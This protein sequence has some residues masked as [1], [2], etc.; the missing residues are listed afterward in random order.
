MQDEPH[1][2]RPEELEPNIRESTT[3]ATLAKSQVMSIRLSDAELRVV[4]GAA[5]RANMSVGSFL[6]RAALEAAE[7]RRLE[8]AVSVE[9]GL[10]GDSLAYQGLNTSRPSAAASAGVSL[11]SPALG[12][13]SEVA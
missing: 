11:Q 6:K 5:R 10:S 7:F 3:R 1:P 4:A 9:F 8:P 2:L 13:R 12:P